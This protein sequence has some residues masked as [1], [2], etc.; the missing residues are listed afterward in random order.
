M[1]MKKLGAFLLSAA[2]VMSLTACGGGGKKL[3]HLLLPNR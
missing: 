1:V 3:M 2:M